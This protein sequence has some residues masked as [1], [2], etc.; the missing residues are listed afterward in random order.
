MAIEVTERGGRQT[1]TSDD[2]RTA[3]RR[4][5]AK[6]SA[7]ETAED[8]RADSG[9]PQF[10]DE[11]PEDSRRKVRRVN[12]R[13]IQSSPLFEV[14]VQYEVPP[15]GSRHRAEEALG[16]QE[17]LSAPP[18][19]EWRQI[20]QDVPIDR[21]VDGNPI[22]NSARQGFATPPTKRIRSIH[23]TIS[24]NQSVFNVARSLDFANAV[25]A[26]QFQ[27]AAPGLVQCLEIVPTSVFTIDFAYINVAYAFEFRD[28]VTWGPKP[29]QLRILDQ[30][31]MGLADDDG[32]IKLLRIVT[33]SKQDVQDA[34]L[35]GTGKPIDSTLKL[36]ELADF[37][38]VSHPDGTP[39][40][41]TLEGNRT[42]AIFLRYNIYKTR[43]FAHLQL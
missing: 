30:G 21:D 9:V 20:V 25:N 5:H 6:T 8:V 32:T 43:T 29:F 19:Y 14:D 12:V 4:F 39:D 3:Q 15:D 23:L 31:N 41:A 24:R 22:V 7:S 27:G 40:G 38:P 37:D 35:D 13:Q 10:N 2:Q 26:D 16:E 11:H 18:V 1:G 42:K 28:D 36:G 34:L 33:D 17:P